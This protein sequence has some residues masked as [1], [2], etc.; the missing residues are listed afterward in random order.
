M[1]LMGFSLPEVIPKYTSNNGGQVFSTMCQIQGSPEKL[2]FYI[3]I[4]VF[5]FMHIYVDTIYN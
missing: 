3:D 4:L 5:Y 2:H 1:M